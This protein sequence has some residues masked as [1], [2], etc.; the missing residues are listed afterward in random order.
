MIFWEPTTITTTITMDF[1]DRT[2]ITVTITMDF[3]FLKIGKMDI[4]RADL[5]IIISNALYF[6]NNRI[7]NPKLHSKQYN[8]TNFY[9]IIGLSIITEK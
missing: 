8:K 4:K 9:S 1:P 3:E 7:P 5:A 6:V 2:T